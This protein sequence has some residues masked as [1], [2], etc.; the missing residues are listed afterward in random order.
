MYNYSRPA[1]TLR[2]GQTQLVASEATSG[3]LTEPA[4]LLDRLKDLRRSRQEGIDAALERDGLDA[5]LFPET[6]GC[7]L[8][9]RAG[10]PSICVPAGYTPEGKP[11]GITFTGTAWSEPTLVKLGYAYE[12]ATQLRKAPVLG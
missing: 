4:Y 7:W 10:Y 12:Q 8:P 2:Y 9:A 6:L 11:F 1:A 5:L 3:T